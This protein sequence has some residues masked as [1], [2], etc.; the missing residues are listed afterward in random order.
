MDGVTRRFVGWWILERLL[1]AESEG[2]RFSP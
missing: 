1:V 2:N